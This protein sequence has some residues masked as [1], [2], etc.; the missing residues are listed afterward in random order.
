[1]NSNVIESKE[2]D[3]ADRN[4]HWGGLFPRLAVAK[5]WAHSP[6]KEI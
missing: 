6:G 4:M 1:M 2:I 3:S 5:A